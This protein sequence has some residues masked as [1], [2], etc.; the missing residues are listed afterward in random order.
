MTEAADPVSSPPPSSSP[1]QQSRPIVR[2][3]VAILCIAAVAGGIALWRLSRH[4]AQ[5]RAFA[6][7]FIKAIQ[8]GDFGKARSMCA[9][10]A[11]ADAELKIYTDAAPKW[12]EV[13]GGITL[14]AMSRTP[15]TTDVTGFLDFEHAP[16]NFSA[17]VITD[18]NG[19]FKITAFIFN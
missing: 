6:E 19:E 5:E 7:N 9:A 13:R 18:D 2:I 1:T 3:F 12:G 11:V 17:T 10:P 16:H 8:A 14:F 4:G 15:G